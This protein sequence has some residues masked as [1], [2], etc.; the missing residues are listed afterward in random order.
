MF[1]VNVEAA[2]QRDDKWFVL[3]EVR[4]MFILLLNI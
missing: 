3:E 2:I 1:I 4:G